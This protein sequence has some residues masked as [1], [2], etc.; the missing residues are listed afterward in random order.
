MS[1]SIF[2]M[3][4]VGIGPSS[5]HTVG[6]MR[7]GRRFV[8]ELIEEGLLPKVTGI[9]VALLGSLAATGVGHS[10]DVATVLGLMMENPSDV[11]VDKIPEWISEI[12]ETRTLDLGRQRI[13]HFDFGADIVFKPLVEDPYHTNTIVFEAFG[14]EGSLLKK[15]KIYSVGGGF[16]ETEEEA[17]QELHRNRY[18]IQATH[19]DL[20]HQFNTAD[21]LMNICAK[22]GLNIVDIVR[23]NER[24]FR[25]DEEIDRELDYIWSV[26]DACIERGLSRDGV[27]AGPYK[28]RRRAKPLHD[29]L[30][31]SPLSLREDPL[32]II[33]WINTFAFAVSEENASGGRVV[34]APTNGAAGII[35]AVLKYYLKFVKGA[36]DEGKRNF[37]L[38]AGAIGA[39]YK[40][41]A[42]ISGAEVGCQGEVGVA[43]SMAAAGLACALG[44]TARQIENAAEIAMEHHLGL[45]C[46]PVAGQVQ[47]PCIERNAVAAV[48]A[49]NS[50]RLAMSGDGTHLISLDQV[51]RT[52]M[53][54]GKDMKTK[55]KE[56]SLGGLAV[57]VVEC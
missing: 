48:K 45:T 39:L 25:T 7:A 52:M 18:S 34:T 46:D 9:K 50:V 54:T 51:I 15:E 44:A 43:C 10:T 5:S 4:R 57:C 56:T 21:E 41:N 19:P 47:V 23:I 1:I 2:D 32:Q 16:I 37:L 13:I 35:P 53:Q 3:Y 8:K 6:P 24:A 42:S 26:M 14:D 12:K 27:L 40:K 20:P 36:S 49:V 28:V 30:M 55:Y 38:T 17:K 11:P 31:R 22:T 29:Q 33:D